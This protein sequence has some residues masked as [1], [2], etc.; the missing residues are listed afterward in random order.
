M[1]KVKLIINTAMNMRSVIKLFHIE[2]KVI[3]FNWEF[4][5]LL[6]KVITL[7]FNY[8]V[9]GSRNMFGSLKKTGITFS[10]CTVHKL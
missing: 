5:S 4:F 3:I 6:I 8:L 7:M 10:G 2:H 9:W 1:N